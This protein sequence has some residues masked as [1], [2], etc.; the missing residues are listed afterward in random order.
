MNALP[1]KFE[2]ADFATR[3]F[4]Q[5]GPYY[6]HR[7]GEQTLVGM[8][9]E[10]NHINYV[11]VAHGGVLT[12]FAD[13]ALSFI[14]HDSERP[15]L[16]IVTNSLTSNFL[17]P[18]YLGDWLEA[19]CRIDRKGRRTAYTSGTIRRAGEPIMTMTGVFT[20][21]RKERSE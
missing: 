21:L 8:R 17:G 4:E 1:D 19:E 12:T 11:G 16:N 9:I 7:N 13:V 14:V 3:F 5:S 15:Q 2:P 18:A 6:L 10:E 20:I